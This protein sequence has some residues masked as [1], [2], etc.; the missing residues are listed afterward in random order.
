MLT[1]SLTLEL[2]RGSLFLVLAEDGRGKLLA[3]Q[4]GQQVGDG[5]GRS[6]GD[7]VSLTD[8]ESLAQ[9]VSQYCTIDR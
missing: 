7:A 9:H 2:A 3:A 8:L 1:Y 4:H 5:G 6:H